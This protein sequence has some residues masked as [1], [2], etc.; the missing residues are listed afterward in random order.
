MGGWESALF[1]SC[2]KTLYDAPKERQKPKAQTLFQLW[3]LPPLSLSPLFVFE[4][5]GES[6]SHFANTHSTNPT[7]PACITYS[8]PPPSTGSYAGDTIFSYSCGPSQVTHA[9]LAT[10][11]NAPASAATHTPISIS[12]LPTWAY[13]CIGVGGCIVLGLVIEL[14][15]K[16]DKKNPRYQCRHCGSTN[17]KYDTVRAGNPNGNG[18]RPYCVCTNLSCPRPDIP[19]H[20]RGWVTWCD[21]VGVEPTN[22]LCRCTP[23]RSARR[24][25][26]WRE[27]ASAP[28]RHFWTCAT[29]ACDYTVLAPKMG[30]QGWG[31]GW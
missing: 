14:I 31:E 21:R 19:Q 22:P 12:H 5:K 4:N 29:G 20:L 27:I 11:T 8:Q 23:A 2:H 15:R 18:G 10:A 24:G 7:A 1:S 16:L 26:C 30:V 25:Y 17:L 9:W 3:N 13:I 6:N 28:G